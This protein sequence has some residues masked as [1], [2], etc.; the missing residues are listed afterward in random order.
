MNENM[1]CTKK[2]ALKSG[3]FYRMSVYF[4][5]FFSSL[6]LFWA[7]DDEEVGSRS[8]FVVIS[9]T[10]EKTPLASLFCKIEGGLDTLYVFSNVEYEM[11]FQ[12]AVKGEDWIKVVASDYQSDIQ[13]VRLILDIAPVDKTFEKRT[14]T[15]S[16]VAKEQYLG[17]FLPVN[18]GFNT[19][20][21]SNF[22]WLSYGEQTGNPYVT[23]KEAIFDKWSPAQKGYNW[24][25]TYALELDSTAFCYGLYGYVKLGNDTVGGD[26]ISPFSANTIVRDTLLILSF[27]AV[28]FTSIEGVQDNN[29]LTVQLQNG[30]V[31]S[32]GTTSRVLD[33]GHID[34]T[35]KN[36]GKD[37]WID[38]RYNFVIKNT[39]EKPFTADMKVRFATGDHQTIPSSGG[40]R[41]FMDNIYLYRLDAN[42]YYLKNGSEIMNIN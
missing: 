33:L 12:T 23:D 16:F 37:M 4:C 3:N 38:A 14:G 5:L 22:S 13:A 32:D 11:F 28:A 2:R 26:L 31:F 39:P 42:S 18:Q 9:E 41:V 15:L 10:P 6:F 40:N 25:S 7:C 36:P 8:D 29:K 30:G 1:N 21:G 27:D 35:S 19:H 34:H 17:Q 20:Y 24:T